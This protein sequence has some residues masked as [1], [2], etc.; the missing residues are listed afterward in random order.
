[1]SKKVIISCALTGAAP[2]M[3][4]SPYVP[5]TP[6]QIAN[7]AIEAGRAGAAIAHIHVRQPD[8]GAAS[9]DLALYKEVVDRIRAS[10]SDIVINLTGGPGAR[11][12]PDAANPKVATADS[13]ISSPQRRVEH[14]LELKPELASLDLSTFNMGEAAFVNV[15][16]HLREMAA[17]MRSAGVKPEL[18]VFDVGGITLGKHLIDKGYIDSPALFQ[19]VLGVQW[20]AEA[21]PETLQFMARQLPASC[22]WSAFG[23]S[24][25]SYPML[26]QSLILGGHVRVGMED[27]LYLSDGVLAESNAQLVERAVKLVQLLGCEVA[28]PSDTRKLLGLRGTQ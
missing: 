8:T 16:E 4:K 21:T 11:Y 12:M 5:V 15:P 1:M 6:E 14:I 24:R 25:A 2:T 26:A 7:S 19:L 13:T 22:K 10:D 23:I 17:A 9:M 18:E 28:T 3:S 27:N 20:A